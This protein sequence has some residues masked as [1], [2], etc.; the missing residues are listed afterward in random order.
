MP[1]RDRRYENLLQFLFGLILF[2][3]LI[4]AVVKTILRIFHALFY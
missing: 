4:D 3:I 2:I 1:L